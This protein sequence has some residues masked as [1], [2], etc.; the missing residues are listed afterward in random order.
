M[1]CGM[2]PHMLVGAFPPISL[3]AKEFLL[4][5]LHMDHVGGKGAY[6]ER[7]ARKAEN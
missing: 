3:R 1:G 5:N 7:K 2:L 6:R 4:F